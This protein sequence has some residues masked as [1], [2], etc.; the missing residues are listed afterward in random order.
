MLLR[1]PGI[2]GL[3]ALTVVVFG[4]PAFAGGNLILNGDFE[5][6]TASPSAAQVNMTNVSNWSVNGGYTFLF[7]PQAGT[8]SGSSADNSGGVGQYG[9]LKLWG[10]GTGVANGLTNSPTGGNFIAQDDNFQQAA[11]SQTVTGLTAGVGYALSFYWAGAQQQGFTGVTEDQWTVNFGSQTFATSTITLPNEAFSGWSKVTTYFTASQ[12]TQVLS[13]LATGSPGG[14]PPFAL[15]DGVSLVSTPEPATWAMM[16]VGFA[17]VGFL[18]R[19]RGF[20]N[21]ETVLG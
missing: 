10:P 16:L 17:A 3:A 19:R 18:V 14:A 13:F 9:N 7:V 15:L 6:T 4:T 20:R 12:S 2:V 1:V 21:S 11:I 8:T 5:T